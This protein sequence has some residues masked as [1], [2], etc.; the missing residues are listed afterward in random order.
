MLGGELESRVCLGWSKFCLGFAWGRALFFFIL[1]N[2]TA[3]FHHYI[4]SRF[5][6]ISDLPFEKTGLLGVCMGFAWG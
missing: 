4:I 6:N 1:T 5:P 3:E 2:Q